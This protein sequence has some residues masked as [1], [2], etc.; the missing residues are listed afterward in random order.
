MKRKI[1]LFLTLGLVGLIQGSALSDAAAGLSPGQTVD[2]TEET[3]MWRAAYAWQSDGIYDAK[4]QLIHVLGKP[5][6]SNGTWLHTIY[7]ITSDTWSP[8][9]NIGWNASGHIYGNLAYDPATGDLFQS[10]GGDKRIKRY[11]K[12]TN[13]WTQLS[14]DIYSGSTP[15]H[16]NGIAWHP[17]LYGP[18]D[19]GLVIQGRTRQ[20]HWRKSTNTMQNA[21]TPDLGANAGHAIYFTAIDK[22]VIGRTPHVLVSS[23]GGGLP[24]IVNVGAPP[25]KTGGLST[26][27]HLPFG[28]M[29]Q[30]PGIPS[31]ILLLERA[32]SYRVWES[33]DGDNWTQKSFNHPF[34]DT[35]VL[36]SIRGHGVVWA[37]GNNGSA[38]S[39]L[40]RPND[41]PVGIESSAIVA[42]P[43]AIS[44]NPNP[45][46][47]V[48]K[49]AVSHQLSAVSSYNLK[50][51]DINGN[52][53]K[54]L[55]NEAVWKPIN[56]PAGVYI[57]K[58][59]TANK[60]ISKRLFLMK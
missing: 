2:F 24:N 13:S 55:T 37:V 42:G 57:L 20:Y 36:I 39:K 34:R 50:I 22:V 46:Y 54:K 18:G 15:S 23:S 10:I 35:Y 21:T 17:N 52:L 44:V 41:S 47:S 11:N 59:I 1:L 14:V 9:V 28:A 56:Q 12:A 51:Y 60:T 3:S 53:V 43:V 40:W 4:H 38:Y 26:A 6:N 49:I 7:N 27:Y 45:F 5:A 32:G 30:H 48:T 58:L 31:K 25:V 19:G 29:I 33:E 8:Y 16:L